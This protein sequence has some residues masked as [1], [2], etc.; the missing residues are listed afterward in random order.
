M[1]LLRPITRS[2]NITRSTVL[3]RRSLRIN[4]GDAYAYDV[5]GNLYQKTPIGGGVGKTLQA[6]PTAQNQLANIGLVYDLAGNVLTDN[7][8][9]HY[10]YDAENRIA[11]AGSWSYSYYGMGKRVLRTSGGTTGSTYWYGEDDILMDELSAA[12]NNGTPAQYQQNIYL[13][14][15]LTARME[16]NFSNPHVYHNYWIL[17]DQVGSSRVSADWTWN[18]ATG[19]NPPIYTNYYPFGGYITTPTDTTLEQRFTGKIR[20]TETGNDY[21]GA[22]YYTGS[23]SR[24]MSPDW[25]AKEEPVPYAK[26]D[27][28][29]SL[30]LYSYVGNNPLTQVDA[31]GHEGFHFCSVSSTQ[32]CGDGIVEPPKPTPQPPPNPPAQ[33]NA[34]TT[35]QQTSNSPASTPT[36]NPAPTGT[37]LAGVLPPCS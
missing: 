17:P 15:R 37:P 29:Q 21:F 4:G 33:N 3:S 13:N 14:G 1:A 12:L 28:P 7:L 25:S 30:N 18:P 35:Q 27:N 5:F 26:L 20:D 6:Q 8:G 16:G 36:Q 23:V 34:N 10:T 2:T 32:L 19:A 24:F 22:R 31:D 9:T 11:T